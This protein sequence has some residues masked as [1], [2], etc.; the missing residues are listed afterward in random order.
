MNY[1]VFQIYKTNKVR[2]LRSKKKF[3]KSLVI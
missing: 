2:L 1:A 3:K